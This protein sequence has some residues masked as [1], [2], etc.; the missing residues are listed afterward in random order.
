MQK[1]PRLVL[2]ALMTSAHGAEF[3]KPVSLQSAFAALS[4]L[5][6]G[7][8]A[9]FDLK[10][11]GAA[12]KDNPA[13]GIAAAALADPAFIRNNAAHLEKLLGGPAVLANVGAQSAALAQA[14]RSDPAL[15]A[16]LTSLRS[17]VGVSALADLGVA[18][19]TGGRSLDGLIQDKPVFGEDRVLREK[20]NSQSYSSEGH[21]KVLRIMA[22]QA[23]LPVQ[24]RVSETPIFL[25][26]EF[27]EKINRYGG[28][29]IA[30]L[31]RPDYLKES[32]K[33]IPQQFR[34]QEGGAH[35]TF[36]Q[37][38]FGIARAA[39]G[40]LQP[41]LTEIQAFPSLY[42]YQPTL[43]QAFLDGYGLDPSF[44]Y[45]M[46]GLDAKSYK[47]RLRRALVGD[48]HPE[49]VILMEIHPER[50]KTRQD[51]LL[52]EKLTG[53]PTVALA[54]VKK[55]GRQLYYV[56]DGRR[57]DIKRIYNRV[58]PDEFLRDNVQASFNFNDD[59][60]VEWVDHPS[61][62]FRMSKFSLPHL[63]HPGVSKS[64]FLDRLESVPADLEN[65]VLKP[66]FSFGGAGIIVGPTAA[67]LAAVPAEKRGEYLLQKRFSFAEFIE[68]PVGAT[69]AEIRVLFLW[70]KG[71]I[72]VPVTNLVRTGR[73]LI[74]SVGANNEPWAGSS[75]AIYPAKP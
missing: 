75:A 34:V 19:Q 69:K 60:D 49:N 53:V 62:Y 57:I 8:A 66:L 2:L 44:R 20:F 52:T 33:A 51:F 3:V 37:V 25:P 68:T 5:S 47:D 31:S 17:D 61:W 50:Q 27:L 42:A 67:D 26:R 6:A 70:L 11:L 36:V 12:A 21:Q 18:V 63:D 29:L 58:V 65:Y 55:D 46:S 56:K 38:D 64:W 23:G 43:A 14:A 45:F 35:P 30:Q 10:A 22:Q 1:L 72:P 41:S 28:E 39:D 48:Y 54:D 71:S 32:E 74:M 40:S 9:G 16:S 24:F 73:G 13:L 4:P 59:L 15:A 7:P